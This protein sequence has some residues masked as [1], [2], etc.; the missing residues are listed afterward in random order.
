MGKQVLQS[1][2]VAIA[3]SH[4]LRMT[5]E[6]RERLAARLKPC[7]PASLFMKVPAIYEKSDSRWAAYAP[8]LPGVIST[9][10]TKEEVRK[11]MQE[12][13]EFHLDGLREDRLPIPEPSTEFEMISVAQR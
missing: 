13:I 9:G 3:P 11:L 7:P 10:R 8:D 6:E 2:S 12:A 4:S 5:R 1:R